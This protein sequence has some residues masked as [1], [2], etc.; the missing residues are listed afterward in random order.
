L[1]VTTTR[2]YRLRAGDPL[3]VTIRIMCS[4]CGESTFG[5]MNDASGE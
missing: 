1:T 4:V 3:S 5:A 2:R